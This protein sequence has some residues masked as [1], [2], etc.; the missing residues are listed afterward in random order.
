MSSGYWGSQFLLWPLRGASS[1]IC[2]LSCSLWPNK[3]FILEN[4]K[5]KEEKASIKTGELKPVFERAMCLLSCT[6]VGA[7]RVT[8][9]DNTGVF[10]PPLHGFVSSICDGEEVGRP[11]VQLTALVLFDGVPAVNVHGTVRVNGHHHLPDVGVD[12]PLF[13]PTKI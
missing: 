12:P 5:E 13:K 3:T 8:W 6:G 9:D 2:F 1:S 7:S 11:L 10:V 4:V